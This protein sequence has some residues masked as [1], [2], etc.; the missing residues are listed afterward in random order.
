VALVD[1]QR[2]CVQQEAAAEMMDFGQWAR[3]LF[4]DG[5][6]EEL[7]VGTADVIPVTPAIRSLTG[8]LGPGEVLQYGWPTVVLEDLRGALRVAPLLVVE[9][10]SI[11]PTDTEVGPA[12]DP[13]LN[14]ALL[15]GAGLDPSDADELTGS[16]GVT[17]PFGAA[18]AMTQLIEGVV[19]RIGFPCTPLAP[20][21][22]G[23]TLPQ[24]VGVYNVA[25]IRATESSNMVRTLI[26]E[27]RELRTRTDW[28]GTAA[29]HLVPVPPAK[30]PVNL[31]D[32]RAVPLAAPW[33]LNDAQEQAV[34]HMRD[35]DLTVITGP[36]GTGKSQV[37]VAAAANAWLQGRTVLL[38]S[39]NN[40]AVDVAASRAAEGVPGLLLRTGNK[41]NREKLSD[42]VR[43]IL[44]SAR[45]HSGSAASARRGL[46]ES[47]TVR[48]K[49]L[50]AIAER[51]RIE[52]LLTNHLLAAE[53]GA[54]R[55]WGAPQSPLP[56]D[57]KTVYRRAGRLVHA[58]FFKGWRTRRLYRAIAALETAPL[59]AIV[60]WSQNQAEFERLHDSLHR[61]QASVPDPAAH[62][63][64][65]EK[66]W[67][68]ASLKA[69]KTAVCELVAAK[70]ASLTPLG[71]T[72]RGN[73]AHVDAT[74]HAM[75]AVRGWACTALSMAQNFP[76]EAGLFDQVIIDE[77]S[78]CSLAVALPLAY[79]AK[80]LIVVGDPSQLTPI[81]SL[82]QAQS[83]RFASRVNLDYQ[84]LRQSGQDAKDGSTF[85]AF[86]HVVG[87]D[88]VLL[89]DEHY[90]CH[91]HIARW[92]NETFYGDA[93]TVLT[94]IS[95]M[96]A[97]RRG[98]AWTDVQGS[99]VRGE[100]GSWVN[101]AEAQAVL[102][103]LSPLLESGR[104]VGVVTPFSAQASLVRG[105][106][107]DRFGSSRLAA[108]EF[109]SG[110]AHRLQGDERDV[111]LFSAVV[112][113]G[114][115]SRSARWIEQNRNLL[116][117]AVS[118]TRQHLVILGHPSAPTELGVPTL[119]ALR[120]A[121][122][123]ED[124]L[125]PDGWGTS[126]ESEARLLEAMY[127]AGLAPLLK[128][129]AEGF[130][131]DFAIR[132][133]RFKLDIEVDGAQ[134]LDL[135]GRQ[136]RRDLARD[137]ILRAEGWQVM[138]FADWR[139]LHEPENVLEEIQAAI[140]MDNEPVD[141]IDG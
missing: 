90:R 58:W 9:L 22:L 129:I 99:A 102:E 114:L 109:T 111:I 113:P 4:H 42:L 115:A 130:E 20:D 86:R 76:L 30:P 122:M 83:E 47:I 45:V 7:V 82:N 87:H 29:R 37:V 25:T 8:K 120:A 105:L 14:P 141:R 132:R 41:D 136:C 81:V 134:H 27:L 110:T 139:C 2:L 18:E 104:S 101:R 118:R 78:Q 106:A 35:H 50:D 140:P 91:P 70:Q 5:E 67:Q 92:F 121:A 43:A 46:H 125:Q 17:L 66:A 95:R 127:A 128:P 74:K 26:D 28:T 33:P 16:L 15:G 119:A 11:A 131:L 51:S 38:A 56:L 61:L 103:L 65:A 100:A 62:L 44:Q 32:T 10:E 39:T 75:R 77:A 57:S 53:N 64:D 123:A 116:N 79:R 107:Q 19:S 72:P 80:R 63:A 55:V 88:Q 54:K 3:V 13:V 85:L 12:D 137:R 52:G 97:D 40:A 59:E 6:L 68:E 31:P 71:N 93:L 21:R 117:V 60:E 89:L 112:A 49:I 126:S 36:P 24:K 23:T 73:A 94:D 34:L 135:R 98:M 108:A 133:G 84:G 1:Y 138:R 96:P 69:V 124:G 48:A